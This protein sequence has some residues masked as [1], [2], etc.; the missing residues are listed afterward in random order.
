ML[1]LM[2]RYP[3][4]IYENRSDSI[5]VRRRWVSAHSAEGCEV[6]FYSSHWVLRW[7]WSRER[8]I[9]RAWRWLRRHRLPAAVW[10][11][12]AALSQIA[13]LQ[14]TEPM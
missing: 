14:E 1:G 11:R 13:V 4:Y 2:D 7:R 10:D 6:F 5:V 8:A 9:T 3:E 12:Q